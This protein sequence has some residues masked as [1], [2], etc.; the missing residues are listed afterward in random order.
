MQKRIILLFTLLFGI[1][2]I[3]FI[4][5]S[6]QSNE[7]QYLVYDRECNEFGPYSIDE[8]EKKSVMDLYI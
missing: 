3:V 1:I 6:G 4:N 2:L 5:F 8:Y 7:P